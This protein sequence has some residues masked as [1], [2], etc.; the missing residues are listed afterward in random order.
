MADPVPEE[1]REEN[2]WILKGSEK[3]CWRGIRK[4]ILTR[5]DFSEEDGVKDIF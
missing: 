2:L 1:G 5:P 3:R 4:S